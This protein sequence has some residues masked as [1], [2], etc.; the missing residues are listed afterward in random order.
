MAFSFGAP[1]PAGG[2]IAAELGPELPD[3]Y[4]EEV[5]FKGVSSDSNV[6]LLPTSWPDDALPAPTSNLLAIAPTQGVVA[7]AGPDVLV[8]ASSDAVRKAISAPTGESKVKTKPFEPQAKIVLPGRPTHIAFASG[9][10][11]LV[12]ATENGAQLSVF[13]T[14]S[15]TAGNAQP[16][17]SI[18]TNGATF[19]ALAPNPAPASEAHSSLVA[20]VT[21]GG[22]LLIAD[23]K[24]GNLLSGPNGQVLK[25]GV[26]SVCW[27]NKGK[28]LVAGLADGTGFQMTP[29]GAQKDVIPR[30]SDLEDDC[31]VS[32]IVWLENDVFLMVYTPNAMEDEDGQTPSSSYYIITRRKGAPFLIQKLPELCTPF[33]L[34]RAPA[35]QFFARIRDY[36]PHL[37]DV[38]IAS[39][40]ASTDVGLI[41]RSDAPL[42]SDDSAK[43]AVGQFAMT[44]VNDDTKR[45]SAPL[46]ES[47]DET[48][49]IGLGV[50][51][52]STDIVVSP[53]AGE[54]ITESSTPLPN[55]LLLS[56]D[57]IL[58][59]WWFIYSE[60]IRQKIPYH[61][62]VS[63]S[64][65]LPQLQSPQQ[66]QPPAQPAAVKQSAF[67]QSGFGA[68][69][70]LGGTSPF[71]K[72]SA[73]PAFGA[74]SALAGGQKPAFGAPS[75]LA[76]AQKPAF[77]SPSLGGGAPAFGKP[78]QPGFGAASSLGQTANTSPF[79]KPGF[80]SMSTGSG[81]GQPSTPGKGFSSFASPAAASGGGFGAFASSGGGGFGAAKPSGE[82]PFAKAAGGSPFSKPSTESPFG[83]PL[84]AG[85]FGKPSGPSPF[86]GQTDTSSAFGPQKTE[87]AKG[88]F[89]MGTSGFKLESTF[90]GDGTAAN[91]LPKP[92]KPSSGLFSMGVLD[93]MV[94]TPTKTSPTSEAMDDGADEPAAPE[95]EKPEPKQPAPSSLFGAPATSQQDTVQ[96]KPSA[97][98]PFGAL[99]KAETP[100]G[101]SLFGSQPQ[102]QQPFGQ[103]QPSKPFSL[104][105]NTAPEKPTSPLSAP[106]EKTAIASPREQPTDTQTS[107]VSSMIEPP[108]PPDS[109]SR[110]AYGPGDTS[111]SSNVSKISVDDAPLPPDFTKPAGG[112]PPLPPDFTKTPKDDSKAVAEE[113]PLPSEPA[114]PPSPTTPSGEP[115]PVPDESSADESE[116][117]GSDGEE[118]ES[119]FSDSGEE[120]THEISNDEQESEPESPKTSTESPFGGASTK[121]PAGGLFGQAPKPSQ[122]QQPSRPLFGEINKPSFPP[123]PSAK[124]PP[125]R[126]I[127]PMRRGSQKS[128][129]Q[130]SN[131]KPKAAHP[132]GS[133]LAARKASLT[134]IAKRE[135]QLAPQLDRV[136][137]EEKARFD[138]QAR[139]QEEEALSLSDD[140]EDERLHADLAQPIQ[141]VPTLDPFLPHQDYSGQTSKPGIPGQIEKL[142]RDINSMVDTLG[143]N[144]RSL[145]SF[146]LYQQS[147][148]GSNWVDI[149]QGEHPADVLDEELRLAEVE[150]LDDVVAK[151]AGSLQ[152]QRVQGVEEKLENCRTLLSKDILALRAQCAS[153]RKTLDAHTDSTAILSA[154]LSAEQANLQQD[155]RTAS[156]DIQAK[157]ADLEF[158]VSLL[159][160]KIADAPRPDGA[161]NGSRK[162]PT[163]EAVVSTIG[164]MM[165]M[166]E[167]KSSDIDFLE[168]QLK[169][170]GVD[171][172]AT[173]AVREGSPF[174]TPKKGVGKFPATPGSR[175]SID[176]PAPHTTPRIRQTGPQLPLEHH[177]LSQSQSSSLLRG[178]GRSGQQT[179]ER[180]VEGQDAAATGS[181]REPEEGD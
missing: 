107:P 23:L 80:A 157:L 120:I 58:S 91:D 176:R 15:L 104:F 37:K 83:K 66:Q 52:S 9:E 26:S 49:V 6:R 67:G 92:E 103:A 78:A 162:R 132:P 20:L 38:L 40:T 95:P 27:S 48:S 8:I 59:S 116:R 28:Q 101:S 160:A 94:A 128:F 105:G 17:L 51:F 158:A 164:T 18:A 146:L 123:A 119:G 163:V 113:A 72:P 10:T 99:S 166:A 175:G 153:I 64:T 89:G 42:A 142:Y 108:L 60:S 168:L 102:N 47:G 25:S 96:S 33:G 114:T 155:L 178:R 97:P 7:G 110:D 39:S 61:G 35:Y 86:G 93:D 44:E 125:P 84:T 85:P 118:D 145:S 57:G 169:K 144:T 12:L 135:N 65:Q 149:L 11:A 181:R 115:G 98:S 152:K 75:A 41:T 126:P 34:K 30:P 76:G 62:M 19:R 5:G 71:G 55:L 69:S 21:T 147:P 74:P 148:S 137:R 106:S 136:S 117:E 109:T 167:A 129:L 87:E 16:A 177:R 45:A 156:T 79:G 122:Q 124:Q 138:A 143:I 151:L 31:H 170:L 36:K 179:G 88:A 161:G 3:L 180:A 24:A 154:P 14:T 68:P 82:S 127:S 2:N 13:P 131:Q 165:N 70:A 1:K 140:D 56:N 112:E 172:Y 90:K 50:D 4:A 46:K 53:I 54:D 150:K 77:G 134:E 100:V 171:T 173:P 22:E 81:F 63:A 141:P 133:T 73:A 32:S 29:E 130:P 121:G 159:R 111:A 174:T 139:Q 43:A